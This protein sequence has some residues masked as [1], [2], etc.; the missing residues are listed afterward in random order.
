MQRED[1]G[2]GVGDAV[3]A[4]LLPGELAERI[5]ALV[6][7]AAP[8]IDRQADFRRSPQGAADASVIFRARLASGQRAALVAEA[9][10]DALVES[11]R[12]SGNRLT[13]RFCPAAFAALRDGLDAAFAADAQDPLRLAD[14]SGGRQATVDFLDPNANKALHV[15]HLRNAA[16]GAAIAGLREARGEKVI[17]QSVVCD[18]GRNIAEAM[19]GLVAAGAEDV[20]ARPDRLDRDLGGLYSSYVAAQEAA[21]GGGPGEVALADRPIGREL[22]V[23]GDAADAIL[24]R[25]RAGDAEVL[26]LWRRVIDRVLADQAATLA[27]LG[28][29]F[30]R[31]V[32]ESAAVPGCDA[33]AADVVERGLG[34]RDAAG[35][36][37]ETGRED[38]PRC[39]LTRS[40]GFATEHLRALVL[41]RDIARS[42]ADAE[43]TGGAPEPIIHVMGEEWLS[44][45]E[46]RLAALHRLGAGEALAGYRMLAHQL[47][48]VAGSDMK[49]SA[50]NA[51]LIDDLLDALERALPPSTADEGAT[52]RQRAVRAA[53]LMP[54]LSAEAGTALDIDMETL[55]SPATNPG[56]ALARLAEHAGEPLPRETGPAAATPD[57]RF[58]LLQAER[59]RR[60]LVQAAD[61]DD[62]VAAARFLLRLAQTAEEEG[63]RGDGETA[64]D[65]AA[66]GPLPRAVLGRLAA[67]GLAALGINGN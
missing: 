22:T 67:A 37:L 9:E 26:A 39:P 46:I 1:T 30:D 23:T 32:P 47:V 8:G 45:T 66:A 20:L 59:L 33:L 64:R 18:I 11:A 42:L 55:V 43:P 14:G 13:L 16:L 31:I 48:R 12:L 5:E 2:T 41:W 34:S 61:R 44:S 35:T 53:A 3:P 58:A 36:V 6:E 54:F 29:R 50:G 63:E 52:A 51:I 19:A 65:A 10:A 60:V 56:F 40:D 57:A 62:P 49:S 25:W 7:R 38:Y 28:I 4:R 24:A 17:R 15:G 21:G 27:R